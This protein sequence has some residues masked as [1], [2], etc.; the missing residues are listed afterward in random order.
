MR[1]SAGGC[2]AFDSAFTAQNVGKDRIT[3]D[4]PL[5]AVMEWRKTIKV[6][7]NLVSAI[8]PDMNAAK[9]RKN[10]PTPAAIAMGQ[11][12]RTQREHLGFTQARLGVMIGVSENA[13][14]QYESGRSSPRR[15]RIPALLN[16]LGKSIA[17]LL[18]GDEPEEE[19]KA[20]TKTEKEILARARELPPEQ[21]EI[22][23]K[24]I[25]ALKN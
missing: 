19:V 20:Q 5:P 13:I 1:Y 24:M 15:E 8:N 3:H 12:I 14:A 4:Q 21:Q 6:G 18:T 2:Q 22:L 23:L 7:G 16:A 11:R 9:S 10:P 17:W 25:S